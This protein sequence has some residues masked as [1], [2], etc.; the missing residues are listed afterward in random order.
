MSDDEKSYYQKKCERQALVINKMAGKLGAAE[1]SLAYE[2][3][4]RTENWLWGSRQFDVAS[5]LYFAVREA[6]NSLPLKEREELVRKHRVY[7]K[8]IQNTLKREQP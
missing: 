1:A 5:R 2:R 4:L 6:L 7:G 8:Y 3:K